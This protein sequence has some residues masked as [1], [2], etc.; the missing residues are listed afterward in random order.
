[1][2]A[3][4]FRDVRSQ[5]TWVTPLVAS[6]HEYQG[7]HDSLRDGPRVTVMCLSSNSAARGR[8]SEH[9]DAQVNET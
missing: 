5:N 3:K 2:V 6:S 1:M 4:A 7:L 9:D 8:L